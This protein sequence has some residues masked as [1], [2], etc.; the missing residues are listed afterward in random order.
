VLE[1]LAT[2]V[3]GGAT[4]DVYVLVPLV[5]VA[6]L[7]GVRMLQALA[8]FVTVKSSEATRAGART[9]ARRNII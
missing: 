6:L 5:Y 1:A 9:S 8:Y 3:D 7:P 2:M 4:G